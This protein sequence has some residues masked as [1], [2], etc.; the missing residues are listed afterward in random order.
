MNVLSNYISNQ[1]GRRRFILLRERSAQ[2]VH[3][4]LDWLF[5]PQDFDLEIIELSQG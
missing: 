4:H 2:H 3:A 1:N 5:T